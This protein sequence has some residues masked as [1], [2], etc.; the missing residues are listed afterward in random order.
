MVEAQ[1]NALGR[2]ACRHKLVYD[3]VPGTV[4]LHPDFP[5]AQVHVDDAAVDAPLASQTFRRQRE[6]RKPRPIASCTTVSWASGK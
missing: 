1:D 2:N 5:I 6:Q 4:V 3:S